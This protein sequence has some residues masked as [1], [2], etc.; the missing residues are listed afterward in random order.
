MRCLSVWV[1]VAA[2][3]FSVAPVGGAQASWLTKILREAG[4][5][6]GD[7]A[8][9]GAGQFDEA[10]S[11]LG[12]LPKKF[13]A[14]AV[15]ASVSPEGHWTFVNRGGQRFT[16]ATPEEMARLPQA[17]F[18]DGTGPTGL[19][20]YVT[21][22]AVFVH[23]AA[24][25]DLPAK[26]R[27]R[28]VVRRKT[29]PL[30][31]R[32][33]RNAEGGS[34]RRLFVDV[35]SNVLV[36]VTTPALFEEAMWQLNRRL[37]RSEIRVL[38]L[39]RDGPA[40]LAPVGRIDAVTKRVLVDKVDAAHLHDAIQSL[41]GQ[42]VVVTGRINGG[43]LAYRTARGFNDA[44]DLKELRKAAAQSDVN[45]VILN[46][47]APRQPGV[48]NW[49][50]QKVDVDGLERALEAHDMA[51]FLGSLAGSSGKVAVRVTEGG[52]RRVAMSVV[53]LRQGVSA[54][55]SETIGDWLAE[56]ASEVAGSV[57][58]NA[59][60]I[61]VVAKQRQQDLNLRIIPG[62]SGDLQLGYLLLIFVGFIGLPFALAWWRWLW[63]PEAREEY[64][65]WFGF[66]TARL[67]RLILFV[68]LFV[69]VV[70]VP[71]ALCHLLYQV[72][73]W[74]TLPWRALRWLFGGRSAETS[75]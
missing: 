54:P 65:G 48:R 36:P 19:T 71:A 9:R 56:I 58:T 59:V 47:P 13:S 26:A 25:K 72:W 2:L 39:S 43:K 73:F 30:Q 49:L 3:V 23:Q 37:Y 11:A 63:P 24:L 45:L 57:V 41:R 12:K 32:T 31:F 46:S 38:S 4:E 53:T 74:I 28:L 7:A 21:K 34:V 44:I 17:L 67:A 68:F 6:G 8:R 75:A 69:P 61:D 42:T 66:Q 35:R 51:D 60:E 29:Y 40:A 27:L 10:V 20:I 22:P 1:L 64:G 5:A 52:Q 14:G 70:G 15:A 62:I 33:V 50:W 18:P 16:A 55:G